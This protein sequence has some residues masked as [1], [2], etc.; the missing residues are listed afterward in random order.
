MDHASPPKYTT[1]SP[2]TQPNASVLS[3]PEA[4]NS[5]PEFEDG[6]GAG[7]NAKQASRSPASGSSTQAGPANLSKGF[8]SCE[9]CRHRKIRCD[10]GQPCTNCQKS[11]IRCV[12]Q[13]R[14]RLPRGRNGGRKKADVEL[15]ARVGRL[16]SLVKTLE[17]NNNSASV[18]PAL[19]H[20]STPGKHAVREYGILCLHSTKP[21]LT[22]R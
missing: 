6:P 20:A 21:A 1:W 22:L 16:E 4:Q 9:M 10:K 12:A 2:S 5:S 8:L 15:K 17:A 7:H 18:D 13:N 3:W 19:K 11:G 14:Q